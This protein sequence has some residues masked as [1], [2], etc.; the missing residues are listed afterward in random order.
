MKVSGTVIEV[1]SRISTFNRP[2]SNAQNYDSYLTFFILFNLESG[3]T[4]FSSNFHQSPRYYQILV[5]PFEISLRFLASCCSSHSSCHLPESRTHPLTL[6]C[7]NW[8]KNTAL[9]VLHFNLPKFLRS[10]QKAKSLCVKTRL[11]F[12]CL[13]SFY[14]LY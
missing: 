5:F 2:L 9:S 11:F 14:Q 8:H 10:V 4:N 6:R 13:F 7:L 12:F 1:G 3:D